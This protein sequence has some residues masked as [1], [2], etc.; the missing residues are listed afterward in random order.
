MAPLAD[1]DVL[2]EDGR[3]VEVGSGLDGDDGVDCAGKALLPWPFDTH[4]HLTG[5][6]ED[7]EL[8]IQH[9]PFSYGFYQTPANLLTTLRLGITSV[10]DA[11]GAEAGLRRAVE[12]GVLVGPRMQVAITMLSQTGGH[13]DEVL[14][15]GGISAGWQPYPGF[16]SG[17]CD[18]VD[19]VRQKVREVIRAGADVIKIA[20]S[21][22]F[23]SPADDPM[24]PTFSQAELDAIVET[25]A[26]LGV[27]VMAHA[28][29]AEGIRRAVRAGVRSIEHGTYLDE[30]AAAMM[31][32]RGTWLVPTLT[33]G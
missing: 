4:V 25:A 5:S 31:V 30:E 13:N 15:S 10:R 27:P 6:Y 23:F 24:H 11:G 19:G 9:R 26:D 8:T 22:G 1:A 12:D 33:A 20:S 2:I 21:G 3:I 7:D 29:G 14:P 16:P 18:G 17:V 28:H 32:E